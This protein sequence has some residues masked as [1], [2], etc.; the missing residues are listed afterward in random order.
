MASNVHHGVKYALRMNASL[1]DLPRN[2]FSARRFEILFDGRAGVAI[3]AHALQKL[4][5]PGATLLPK[6]LV[7]KS[8][9]VGQFPVRATSDHAVTRSRSAFFGLEAI[10][11]RR[12]G[13]PFIYDS[14]VVA[15]SIVQLIV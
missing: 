12:T 8:R 14:S 9:V 5:Q 6:R 10:R 11:N 7:D 3:F 4:S 13:C 15:V 2:H 1:A